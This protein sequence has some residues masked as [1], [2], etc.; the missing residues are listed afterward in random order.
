M[1][2]TSGRPTGLSS[3]SGCT[4]CVELNVPVSWYP[5]QTSSKRLSAQNPYRSFQ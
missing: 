4:P 1:K 3:A 2:I 5:V